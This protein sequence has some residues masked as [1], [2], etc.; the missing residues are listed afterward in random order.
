MSNFYGIIDS[1]TRT[2]T[3]LTPVNLIRSLGEFDLDPCCP[4]G[5]P[6][7]TAKEFY[8]LDRGQD[9]LLLPWHG[10]VWLNPPYSNWVKFIEKL[11][12][13]NNGIA[14]IFGRTETK[15]FFD[16]VWE[17]AD[18]IMF[19]KK[20]ISFVRMDLTSGPSTAPSVLIA[21]G[22]NNTEALRKSGIVGKLIFLK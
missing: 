6:W 14:L 17:N 9:G 10:R 7:E 20:R 13:H 11:K 5:V 18:S 2:D 15:G 12:Q 19:I 4:V 22:K 21:Y 1:K 3:W 8:S 16:H